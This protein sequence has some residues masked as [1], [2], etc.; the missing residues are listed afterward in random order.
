MFNAKRS[1]ALSLLVLLLSACVQAPISTTNNRST[2]EVYGE[3]DMGVGTQ[4]IRN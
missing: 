4:Q 2:V 3:V 1:L